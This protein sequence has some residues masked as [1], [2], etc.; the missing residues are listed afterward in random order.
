[1]LKEINERFDYLQFNLNCL[2]E[3]TNKKCLRF[4]DFH[5]N[6]G[7]FLA[8]LSN[9][10]SQFNRE[11]TLSDDAEEMK[12]E[13]KHIEELKKEMV[14]K[15]IELS[16]LK[17]EH[18][19]LYG[20][21]GKKDHDIK[22]IETKWESIC[23]LSCQ[24]NQTVRQ[25]LDDEKELKGLHRHLLTWLQQK[26]RMI[27]AC[28]SKG[29]TDLE[30]LSKQ[31]LQ[32]ELLAEE[33]QVEK[34]KYERFIETGVK[35]LERCDA[36][37]NEAFDVNLKLQEVNVEWESVEKDLKNHRKHFQKLGSRL[38]ELKNFGK[39]LEEF[40][41]KCRDEFLILSKPSMEEEIIEQKW[42]Q[43][44]IKTS[45]NMKVFSFFVNSYND[46]M[47]QTNDQKLKDELKTYRNNI[48]NRFTDL[49]TKIGT[50]KFLF[51][52]AFMNIF[53]LFCWTL[54]GVC[55]LLWRVMHM[56]LSSTT[57]HYATPLQRY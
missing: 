15:E 36:D 32:F 28:S 56:M 54:S 25:F 24:W 33:L 21:T 48:E 41:Q 55:G 27:E 46:L 30:M 26:G 18:D 4:R 9:T 1:M 20:E 16:E 29:S 37:S 10:L 11:R 53:G 49:L 35:V 47:C 57:Q 12:M 2:K 50:K 40:E 51:I 52:E 45:E 23:K 13:K 8:W 38:A 6:K 17:G 22:T 5:K 44:D 42:K 7:A 34:M 14:K 43:I 31:K 3:S 39:E 19:H